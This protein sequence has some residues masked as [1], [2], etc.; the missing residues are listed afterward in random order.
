MAAVMRAVTQTD[1][2]T[3]ERSW[4]EPD[5]FAAV[6]DRYYAEIHGFASRRLG[7][8]LADDVAA[9]TFLIAFDRRRRYDL[10]RPDARP[11]LYGIASNLISRHRRAEVRQYRALARAGLAQVADGHAERVE[12]RL[13]AEALR[14]RLAAALAEVADRDRDVLLLVAW[15]QLSCDEAARALGIPAGTA[16]SRLHRARRKT[17]AALGGLDPRTEGEE[18]ER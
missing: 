2:A 6:F 18:A 7:G 13:D 4:H 17:R 14:G 10:A 12:G 1:A 9:E 8:S 15:A 5:L 11:W 16:R 3:I